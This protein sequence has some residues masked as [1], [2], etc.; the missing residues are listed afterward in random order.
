MSPTLREIVER[1]FAVAEAKDLDAFL[2]CF[3]DDAVLMDPHYPTPRMVGKAAIAEGL[4]W[5]FS[6]MK[7][8]GFTVMNYF[9][10]EDGQRA[11]IE[12]ATHHVLKSG[13]KLNFSQVFVIETRDGLITRLQAYEPYG[14]GGIVGIYLLVSR[15]WRI[16]R[17]RARQGQ[18]SR[19]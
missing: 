17:R 16:V 5:G 7:Q 8:F 13:M 14:P 10:S 3:T 11:A 4:R 6:G 12:M 18:S 2:A 19:R 15:L 9:E 1:P